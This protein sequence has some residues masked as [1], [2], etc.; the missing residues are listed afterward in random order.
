M[1]RIA[2]LSSNSSSVEDVLLQ[3]KELFDHAAVEEAFLKQKS[4]VNWLKAGNHNTVYF[5]R[6]IKERQSKKRI[7]CL[8][9]DAGLKLID[10]KD[11]KNEL[12]AFYQTFIGIEDTTIS[13]GNEDALD[14]IIASASLQRCRI[15]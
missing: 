11:I 9:N 7:S 3:E 12:I 10:E 2:L 15:F 4:R 6:V 13:G 1:Q 5:H 14:S 8:I